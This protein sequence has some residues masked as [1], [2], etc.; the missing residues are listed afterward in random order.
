MGEF[1]WKSMSRW[2]LSRSIL[3]VYG[4]KIKSSS[5]WKLCRITGAILGLL[6]LRPM[7]RQCPGLR[8]GMRPARKLRLKQALWL[9]GKAR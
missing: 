7:L 5:W 2:Y 1:P 6:Q 3:K 8:P 9:D 4:R